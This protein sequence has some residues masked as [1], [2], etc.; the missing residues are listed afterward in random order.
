MMLLLVLV[1][2]LM[3][4]LLDLFITACKLAALIIN[5]HHQ[6]FLIIAK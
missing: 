3:R 6:L 2:E 1:I 5:E 4:D